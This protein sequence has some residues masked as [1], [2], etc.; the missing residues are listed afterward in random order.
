MKVKICGITNLEDALYCQEQGADAIGFIFY[1]GSR[2]YIEPGKAAAIIRAL[3]PFVMKVGVFVNK[4]FETIN[5]IS[6]ST[7]LNTVQIHADEE[8]KSGAPLKYP[9]I[10]AYRI[11]SGFDFTALYK[12]RAEYFLLDSFSKKGYGGT[13]V[14]FDWMLIPGDLKHRVILA[15]GV[16]AENLEE[17]FTNIKPSAIDLSSSL[18]SEPGKKDFNK[19][20]EFFK[21]YNSLKDLKC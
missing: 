6:A 17:I 2:R 12:S 9:A 5:A 8:I 4:D 18:E 16:S 3:S 1:E 20:D 13:G 19:V 10:K 15:G 21:K 7:G 14:K 11:G